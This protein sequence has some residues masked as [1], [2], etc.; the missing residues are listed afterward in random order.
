MGKTAEK[1]VAPCRKND[2]GKRTL[3]GPNAA[4]LRLFSVAKMAHKFTRF[5]CLIPHSRWL[6]KGWSCLYRIQEE[7]RRKVGPPRTRNDGKAEGKTKVY[8]TWAFK[9]RI[10]TADIRPKFN[11]TAQDIRAHWSLSEKSYLT[12]KLLTS[13][14]SLFFLLLIPFPLRFISYFLSFSSSFL[15]VHNF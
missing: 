13:F 8:T 7:G 10:S 15:P 12:G 2:L 3:P 1:C 11:A 14:L 4:D 6:L 5:R 9:K